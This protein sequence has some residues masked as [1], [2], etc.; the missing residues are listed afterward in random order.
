MKFR[1]LEQ[2]GK[3]KIQSWHE[4]VMQW[5][6]CPWWKYSPD[7]FIKTKNPSWIDVDEFVTNKNSD[8]FEYVVVLFD[9]YEEAEN[10]IWQEW[11]NQGWKAIEKPEW[12]QV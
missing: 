1:I 8:D 12:R 7:G 6:R 10:Y 5:S 2:R 11:G 9:S 4:G 3:Y